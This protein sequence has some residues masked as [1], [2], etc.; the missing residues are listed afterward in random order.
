MPFQPTVPT[1]VFMTAF[2]VVYG[3]ILLRNAVRNRMDLYD[4]ML[5]ATV[6]IV[7][8]CF[9]YFPGLVVWATR[10]V[11]VEFPFLLLFGGLF[12]VVFGY[13][14]RLVLMANH[15]R[16]TVLVL[17]QELGLLRQQLGTLGAGGAM[18]PAPGAGAPHGAR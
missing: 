16:R 5:L 11:G 14:H 2:L 12:V 10:L 18:A 9:V 8:S 4:V 6:A 1:V 7:P 17:T 15:Q 3:A 13:L